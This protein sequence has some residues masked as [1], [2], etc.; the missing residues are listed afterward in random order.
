MNNSNS[1]LA[2]LFF[3]IGLALGA[4][5]VFMV[6]AEQRMEIRAYKIAYE[7]LIKDAK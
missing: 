4:N 6:T 7:K 3:F 5:I 1:G 2:I